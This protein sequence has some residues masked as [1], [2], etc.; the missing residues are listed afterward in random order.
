MK[1]YNEKHQDLTENLVLSLNKSRQ[2]RA[3]NVDLYIHAKALI[4]NQYM[5][6]AG[7]NS[8]VVAISGGIDS[9]AVLSLVS[10][11]SKQEGSPIKKIV[12]V[13]IP[14]FDGSVTNQ[15]STVDKAKELCSTLNIELA[16]L[17]ITVPVT[18]LAKS[19]EDTLG[20]SSE[21]MWS[22]GQ[23]VSYV[24]TPSLYYYTTVL[25]AQGFKPILVGTINRDEG[26]YL[27]FLCK[28]GDGCVDVQLISDLHK[29][30]V[31]KV[32]IALNVPEIIIEAIPTG[33]MYDARPDED[34]FGAPYTFVELF[35]SHKTFSHHHWA[36][37]TA[38]WNAEDKAQWD[39]YSL[40]LNKL[41]R[42]NAHKYLGGSTAVHLD[43]MDSAVEGGWI[44][45]V[46]TTIHKATPYLK[47]NIIRTDKFVGFVGNSP[48][49]ESGVLDNVF[50]S[51]EST[52]DVSLIDNILSEKEV[53]NILDWMGKHN[54]LLKVTNE[55]GY[56]NNGTK[57][58]SSRLSFYDE[59]WAKVIYERLLKSGA[60][61]P[62]FNK[63]FES[64]TTNTDDFK[65][66][67]CVGVGPLF[68]VMKY[69]KGS[70]LYP[71]YDDS[72]Y[73][74]NIRRSLKTLVLVVRTAKIGG[75]TRFL[76]DEQ[77]S[78]S[79]NQRDFSDK[80][81]EYND[82]QV[83]YKLGK[84]GCALLFNHRLLHDGE[85]VYDGEKIIIRTDI[86]YEKASFSIK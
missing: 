80:S 34:V 68:R 63:D 20:Q 52:E 28:S 60:L 66:W 48:L 35:L 64:D 40:A 82:S 69:T 76:I 53:S 38:H 2:I 18:G 56:V 74:S 59:D 15:N 33:D 83:K 5:L 16:V 9:A 3:F 85:K 26:A 24:R 11:A 32:A 39:K 45:G 36:D 84:D 71:H 78:L 86:M 70:L 57:E 73:Q 31:Y 61:S 79:F 65:Q 13:T 77:E 19:I 4:L 12:A 37:I 72:F 14:S 25:N 30:E 6:N 22:R 50:K 46:H 27:G 17:D 51:D 47:G 43:V 67:R 44:E 1:V 49:L 42:Y 29:Y 81:I 21:D 41:H 62:I 58:G 55:Y 8:C 23:L 54:H 75:K 10:H 7:L